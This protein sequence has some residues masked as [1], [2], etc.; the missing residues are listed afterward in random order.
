[1]PIGAPVHLTLNLLDIADNPCPHSLP[2]YR[3]G[4]RKLSGCVRVNPSKFQEVLVAHIAD[5]A[6]GIPAPP[7]RP[8]VTGP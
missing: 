2:D 6:F 3:V 5:V 1:V 7:P 4:Q 8:I